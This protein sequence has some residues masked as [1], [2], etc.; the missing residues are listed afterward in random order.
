LR[1][2]GTFLR[3]YLYV[4]DVVDAYLLLSEKVTE[5]GV[6]GQA[7]NFGPN[8]PFT[9]LDMTSAILRL[10]KREDLLPIILDDARAEIHDQ[11]LDGEK[12]RRVI[13][14]RPRWTLDD[15]LAATISWYR[16][17]LGATP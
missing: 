5:P 16:T 11:Y 2:D 6:R 1:S 13:G 8:K 7:F 12:A 3:D 15:G 14:F 4:E 9:V 10:M 17:Y